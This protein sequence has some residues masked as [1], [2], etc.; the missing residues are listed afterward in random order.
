MLLF[1]TTMQININKT[2]QSDD[3]VY[4][5]QERP[6]GGVKLSCGSPSTPP[7]S[8]P[9]VCALCFH[10]VVSRYCYSVMFYPEAPKKKNQNSSS[11]G[12]LSAFLFIKLPQSN[13]E[14]VSLLCLVGDPDLHIVHEAKGLQIGPP[15]D[16]QRGERRAPT[17]LVL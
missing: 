15:T 13:P 6:T 8:H 9:I 5:G 7:L 11:A 1:M 17:L 14:V 3:F 12:I 4:A 2:L 10:P 16:E